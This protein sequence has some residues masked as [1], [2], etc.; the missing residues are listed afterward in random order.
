MCSLN[1]Q[2]KLHCSEMVHGLKL[3]RERRGNDSVRVRRAATSGQRKGLELRGGMWEGFQRTSIS[4]PGGGNTGGYSTV[5]LLYSYLHVCVRLSHCG[6]L[7]WNLPSLSSIQPSGYQVRYTVAII[8]TVSSRTLS[9]SH[10]TLSP[11]NTSPFRLPSTTGNHYSFHP[12][13]CNQRDTSCK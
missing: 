9:S 10:E 1:R 11:V 13:E 3:Q 12:Y 6:K 4:T 5:I 8:T 2:I 7:T